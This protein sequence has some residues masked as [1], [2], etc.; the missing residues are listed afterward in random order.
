MLMKLRTILCATS[1]LHCSVALADTTPWLIRLRAIDVIPQATSNPI[2]LIGG[3]VND[4]SSELVPELDISYFLTK[5]IAAELVL[6]TTRHSVAANNTILGHV[7]LGKVNLLPP[8]LT[9]QYH[10][11][12]DRAFNPYVG[13]GLNYT[14][15]Y[16]VNNGPVSLSTTY[17]NSFGPA[18]QAGVDLALNS[19]WSV[20]IDVKKIFI[21]T[22]VAVN[23]AVGQLNPTVKINPFVLGV[24]VGYR[25]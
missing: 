20:N 19:H 9:F 10:F 8:T 6:A 16:H 1:L 11:M 23:T 25:V 22:N 24:G 14:Y 18:L 5:Q 15:F 13:L 3:Q 4:I 21:Q 7:D 2:N 12:P 17:G